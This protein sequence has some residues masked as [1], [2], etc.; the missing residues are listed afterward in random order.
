MSFLYPKVL[1]L[2]LFIPLFI[3]FYILTEKKRYATLTL[4]T[5]YRLKG[6]GIKVYAR[7]LP[8]ILEMIS[9]GLLFVALAR[10][11]NTSSINVD[12]IEGIDIMLAIDAS[13]S[14]MAM[15]LEPNRFE[16]A[17]AV[18]NQFVAQ[19]PN[20]NI[21]L[22]L[23]AGESFTRCP[24]TTDHTSLIKRLNESELGF[25]E[26]GTAIGMG[27]ISACNH[28]K[29]SKTKSKIVVLLTDGINNAG[30]ITPSTAASIAL[31]LGI[32]IY[33]IAIGAY[34]EAPFPIQTNF[35]T[36]VENV[37]VEI[38][39]ASLKRIAQATGAS[40]YRA[41]DNQKL[42]EIY[43][44]IDKLE[45]SKLI[46]KETQ[47]YHELYFLWTLWALLLLLLSLILRSTYCRTNP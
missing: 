39:E 19:R 20:D 38:D 18:A 13:G 4:P 29:E 46:T 14:M 31:S 41:T 44:E 40:Y 11:R 37:K 33:T 28:L 17:K 36:I 43:Q 45:K 47:A 35:G 42:E 10:P 6:G 26:D 27:I 22:V 32:R 12:K 21:G 30:S 23:F 7:H 5:L 34:G 1:W 16:A 8:F 25:L 15:D 24:L 2:L 9:L 3:L